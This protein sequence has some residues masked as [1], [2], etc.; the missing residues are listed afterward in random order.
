VSALSPQSSIIISLAAGFTARLVMLR[1]DYRQYPTYPHGV[2]THLSQGL[3]AALLGAVLIPAMVLKQYT[4]VTFMALAAQEFRQVRDMERHSLAKVD[5]LELVPRG[6]DYIEGIA[7]T[8]EARCY[9]TIATSLAV[10]AAA[11]TGG[12]ALAV[13]VWILLLI[14]AGSLRK[15]KEIGDVADVQPAKLH[16]DGPLLMVDQIVIMNVGLEEIRRKILAEGMAVLIRPKDDNARATL[17]QQGQRQAIIHTAAA[18][19]GTKRDIGE[20][21]YT[22]LARKDIDT[23]AV[24]LFILPLEKDFSCLQEIINRVPVLESASAKPL[25]TKA[26]RIASD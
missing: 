8:F 12:Y 15:G 5:E 18:L 25:S 14:V 17:H 26:G 24:G 20:L 6:V 7:K 10:S 23:G 4:A 3:V 21:D 11:L 13:V 1:T 19:L 16:F 9:L 22:P 2:I